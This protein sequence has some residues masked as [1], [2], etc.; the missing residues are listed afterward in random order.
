MII[1]RNSSCYLWK[2]WRGSGT[3][4]SACGIDY[5][6][7]FSDRITEAYDIS[8]AQADLYLKKI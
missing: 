5:L 2:V 8:E 3:A 4:F 1:Q 6:A 7:S